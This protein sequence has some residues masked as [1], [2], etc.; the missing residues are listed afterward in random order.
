MKMFKIRSV[1]TVPCHFQMVSKDYKKL[2][3]VPSF[4]VKKKVPGIRYFPVILMCRF[5]QAVCDTRIY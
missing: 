4:Y 3:D 1:T 5:S 2:F